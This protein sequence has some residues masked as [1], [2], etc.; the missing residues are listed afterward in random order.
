MR[1]KKEEKKVPKTHVRVVETSRRDARDVDHAVDDATM[2]VLGQCL[3]AILE[4]D[5][6]S[7]GRRHVLWNVMSDET[8]GNKVADLQSKGLFPFAKKAVGKFR[9]LSG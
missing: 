5:G 9:C 2:R 6:S 4:G 7:V 8:F 1:K 3:C